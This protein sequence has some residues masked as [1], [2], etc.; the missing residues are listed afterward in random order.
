MWPT[1]AYRQ[2]LL[3]LLGEDAY[4]GRLLPQIRRCAA[5]ALAA[6]RPAEPREGARPAAW[7]RFGL[8]FLVDQDL[9]VWLIEVNYNPG[10]QSAR[11]RRG[12]MKRNLVRRFC[13]AEQ[14]LRASRT[15]GVA[16]S[17][18]E[19][20]AG[21]AVGRKPAGGVECLGSGSAPL[22]GEDDPVEPG[23]HGFRLLHVPGWG[24]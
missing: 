9:G 5:A 10:M 16:A 1:E 8:D 17:A 20:G 4:R 2:H 12:E 14:Q 18:G 15:P 21:A 23:L 19:A 24:T 11:G 3:V 13:D 7:K 22:V 6:V